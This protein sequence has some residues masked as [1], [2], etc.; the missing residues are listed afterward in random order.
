MDLRPPRDC[1]L[2]AQP[3]SDEQ[4]AEIIGRP[5]SKTWRIYVNADY[6][7]SRTSAGWVVCQGSR[8]ESA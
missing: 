8:D 4:L 2:P 7:F 3:F 5:V 6:W 1:S